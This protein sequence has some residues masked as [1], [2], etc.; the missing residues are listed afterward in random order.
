MRNRWLVVI[1]VAS[2]CLNVAVVGAY[3]FRRAHRDRQHGFAARCLTAEVRE[4]MR[5]TRDAAMPAFSALVDRVQSTD[6]L[7]WTEMRS[8]SPDSARVESL[9]Q[10]LGQIHGQMRAMVCRQMHHEL[11]LMPAEARAEYL[12]HMM[13]M[14]PGFGGPGA[15]M[16]R[17][18]R[19]GSMMPAPR[20]GEPPSDEPPPGPPP[21][22]GD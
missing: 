13:R 1:V 4:K 10:E 8:E 15:G 11:Q 5:K 17:H 16:G 18:M 19:R 6:S 14:R 7:L 21:E 3:L 12:K 22:S 2:L 9:C 20:E